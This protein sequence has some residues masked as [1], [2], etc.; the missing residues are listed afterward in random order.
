MMQ[1]VIDLINAHKSRYPEFDYYIPHMQEAASH[2]HAQP[3]RCIE[4]CKAIF[5]GICKALVLRMDKG[6]DRKKAGSFNLPKLVDRTVEQIERHD[7]A[8]DFPS[9]MVRELAKTLGPLRNDRGDIA[10]GRAA[11]KE[12][13]SCER[14]SRYLLTNT[15]T[16]LR[17]MLEIFYE[18]PGVLEETNVGIPQIDYEDNPEFNKWLDAGEYSGGRVLFSRALYEQDYESYLDQLDTYNEW[19]A[20]AESLWVVDQHD[21]AMVDAAAEHGQ[22]EPD[23]DQDL[24]PEDRA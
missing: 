16:A 6:V 2:V 11:P 19:R 1:S 13:A 17:Y 7:A 24:Y 21:E 5:E 22:R 4:N 10:H 14:L 12:E 3:D 18:Q 9:A 15:E 8:G 20:E 23:A